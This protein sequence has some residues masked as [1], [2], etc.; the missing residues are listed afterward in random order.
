MLA[1]PH[2]GRKWVAD[3]CSATGSIPVN[4]AAI[5][6]RMLGRRR[7]LICSFATQGSGLRSLVAL[8]QCNPPQVA[9]RRR[10]T[11]GLRH[12][13]NLGPFLMGPG[14]SLR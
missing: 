5:W 9:N 6:E 11:P 12:G 8:S 1:I 13:T 10:L 3:G 4:T 2:H 14:V 7:G